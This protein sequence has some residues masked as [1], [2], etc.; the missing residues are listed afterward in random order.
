MRQ[1]SDSAPGLQACSNLAWPEGSRVHGAHEDFIFEPNANVRPQIFLPHR[2]SE[3]GANF[4][5]LLLD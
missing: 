5:D 1:Y 3:T 4:Q 2:M